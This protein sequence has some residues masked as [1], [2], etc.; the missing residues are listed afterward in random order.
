MRTQ[1]QDHTLIV[2]DFT[3]LTAGN[4]AQTRD[5][6]RQMLTE[7]HTSLDLD[8]TQVRFIDSHGISVLISLHKTLCQRGG[9]VRLL[10]PKPPV[11]Q[12]L[13]LLSFG[14]IFEIVYP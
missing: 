3:E 13:E 12:I 2:S 8:L 6:I 14:T 1:T 11:Y 7:I 5:Y 4:G 10:H 9:K